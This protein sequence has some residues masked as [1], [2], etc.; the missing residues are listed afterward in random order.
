[1]FTQKFMFAPEV[2]GSNGTQT[3]KPN[4]TATMPEADIDFMDVA[5]AVAGTW[6]ANPAITL[7]WKTSSDFDKDVQAYATALGSRQNTGSLR[8]G[9]TQNLRLL[10]KKIDDAVAEVKV[11]IER[12]FKTANATAQFARYGIVKEN[13][14]YMISRDR[15]NR[16]AS[17]DLMIAAIAADGFGSEEY[18]SAFWTSMKTDYN[19]ALQLA[20]T[21]TGDLSGKVAT[22][23]QQ[24]QA[25]KK[26]LA[27]LLL[28]LRGNYPETYPEMYRLWGWKKESY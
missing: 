22:K 9:L 8:P 20:S 24:K 15:N 4:T 13:R 5:K 10:D 3:A 16:N 14:A 28:L 21:T 25:I 18:G 1:M 26:V 6:L 11:Y 19:A 2:A 12:K 7:L 23:N 27:A 17:F